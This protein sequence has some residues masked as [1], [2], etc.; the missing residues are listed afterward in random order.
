MPKNTRHSPPDNG[1]AY[2]KAER[3]PAM[4]RRT[5]LGAAAAAFAIAPANAATATAFAFENG[6]WF[7]GQTF[8]PRTM[9]SSGGRFTSRRPPAAQTLDL[10]GAF[11]VPP[12]ADAHNH[13]LG[14]HPPATDRAVID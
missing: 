3:A 11:I 2:R 4:R 12:F 6:H 1:A 7:D 14:F 13:G 8:R 9:F 5:F 10:A